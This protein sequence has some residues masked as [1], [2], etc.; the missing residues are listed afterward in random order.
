[1]LAVRSG[2]IEPTTPPPAIHRAIR[3]KQGAIQGY[4]ELVGLP[5]VGCA[6]LEVVLGSMS[7]S[8]GP[9][10]FRSVEVIQASRGVKLRFFGVEVCSSVQMVLQVSGGKYA[11]GLR[12]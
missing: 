8:E 3:T 10:S 6:C 12:L 2:F 9:C 4:P 1:M 7:V 11:K 5:W